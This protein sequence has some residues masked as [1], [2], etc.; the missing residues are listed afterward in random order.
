MAEKQKQ[1]RPFRFML[2]LVAAAGIGLGAAAIWWEYSD[3]L[4][5]RF[6]PVLESV[7]G[8]PGNV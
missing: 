7:I 1:F 2:R 8:V 6:E 4:I 3:V 5:S